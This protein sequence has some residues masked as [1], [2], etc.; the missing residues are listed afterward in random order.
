[1]TSDRLSGKRGWASYL[2]LTAIGWS[3]SLMGQIVDEDSLFEAATKA[4]EDKMYSAA[5]ASFE[6]FLTHYQVSDRFILAT[7]LRLLCRAEAQY[8]RGEYEESARSFF[9]LVRTFPNSPRY[10]LALIGEAQTR[11][12]LGETA[13]ALEILSTADSD[14]RKFFQANP[15]NELAVRGQLLLI[16]L[17]IEGGRFTDAETALS[18]LPDIGSDTASYWR[19]EFLKARVLLGKKQLDAAG[20]VVASLLTSLGEED[21]SERYARTVMLKASILEAK[22]AFEEARVELQRNIRPEAPADMRREALLKTVDLQ[23]RQGSH[24]PALATLT[25]FIEDYPEDEARD[26]L[27]LT[28]GEIHLSRF[29]ET[30]GTNK[31]ENIELLMDAD[32]F[33]Q[34]VIQDH[35][36]SELVGDAWLNRGWAMWER[37]LV[38]REDEIFRNAGE[39]FR[40]AYQVLPQS[41]EKASAK[42]KQAD[43]SFESSDFR[44]ATILYQEVVA[45]YEVLP[46][47]ADEIIDLALYRLVKA[48]VA[49]E[50]QGLANRAM[51]EILTRFQRSNHFEQRSYLAL[52]HGLNRMNRPASEARDVFHAFIERFPQ[53]DLIPEAQL[54]LARSFEREGNWP[55]AIEIYDRWM[56]DHGGHHNQP[57]A[58]YYRA[59]AYDANGQTAKALDLLLEF[60]EEFSGHSLAQLAQNRVADYYWEQGDIVAAEQNYQ[61]VFQ[62]EV[63]PRNR[64]SYQARIMA[65]RCAFLRQAYSA[66]RDYLEALLQQFKESETV[67]ADLRGEAWFSMGDVLMTLAGAS[68]DERAAIEGAIGAFGETPEESGLWRA[69]ALGRIGDCYLQLSSAESDFLA[70]AFTSYEKARAHEGAT[71]DV[72]SLATIAMGGIHERKGDLPAATQCYLEVLYGSALRPGE[73]AI[74]YYVQQAGIAAIRLL[75]RK[76]D[77]RGAANIYRRLLSDYP[78]LADRLGPRL[79]L[80]EKREREEAL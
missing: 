40:A 5:E 15:E 17:H 78:F 9:E 26:L 49:E 25:Q 77:W 20:A 63:W 52:G 23:M 11:A 6:Q 10:M 54:G 53:S 42:F 48:G 13:R 47:V 8:E 71:L 2:I 18:R 66:A 3:V 67:A 44:S 59:V 75:E 4:Y 29:Y 60:L 21:R 24:G 70:E 58:Q 62:S 37:A 55:S 50:D 12:R 14:F 34:Q 51:Q 36:E 7:E 65:S 56:G 1:M 39:A 80:M 28:A 41:A 27:K 35:P 68:K 22:E 46:G 31:L 19:V 32:S 33:F 69:R 16:E 64:V 74:S 43:C 72:R 57:S 30:A 38:G 76:R 45:E 73:T 79:A 61:H